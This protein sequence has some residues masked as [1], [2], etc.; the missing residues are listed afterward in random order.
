MKDET[1][2]IRDKNGKTIKFSSWEE[3]IKF[4]KKGDK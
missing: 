4:I 1:W 3:M 2:A